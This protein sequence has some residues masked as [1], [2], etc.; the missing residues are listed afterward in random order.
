MGIEVFAKPAK[1]GSS[2]GEENFGF[3]EEVESLWGILG[4]DVGNIRGRLLNLALFVENFVEKGDIY[5]IV[6]GVVR[7][8]GGGERLNLYVMSLISLTRGG[9]VRRFS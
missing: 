8:G 6:V 2:G 5:V 4:G 3:S 9:G 1:P 7:P